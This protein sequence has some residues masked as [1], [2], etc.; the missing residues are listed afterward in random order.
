MS[1]RRRVTEHRSVSLETGNSRL[2]VQTELD[3]DPT[4]LK[5]KNSNTDMKYSH[6]VNMKYC[7]PHTQYFC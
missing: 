7:T 2:K 4:E 3:I 1:H 5:L 6:V